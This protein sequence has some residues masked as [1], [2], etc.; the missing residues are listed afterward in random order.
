MS[1]ARD[2][3]VTVVSHPAILPSNQEVYRALLER[4]FDV[5]LVV[6]T[7]WPHPY[8]DDPLLPVALE[9]MEGR[10]HPVP[11]AL[12]GR[13]QR[14]VPLRSPRGILRHL[15]P[16]VL[17]IEEE[18]FAVATAVW[19]RAAWKLRIP[20]GVQIDE[21]MDRPMPGAA[22]RWRTTVL[23]R[24]SFVMA[25]SD[26]AIDQARA[27]G[28]SGEVAMIAHAVEAWEQPAHVVDERFRIGYIGRLVAEK[29]LA[30]L[31]DAAELMS[32]PPRLVLVGSGPMAGQLGRSPLVEL[33]APVPH[34]EIPR[35]MAE[36][37]VLALP[38][39]STATWTEQFGRVLV[40]ANVCAVPVVG[41]DS[42]EI[43]WVI[44]TT[45]GGVIVPEGD[46][47]ALAD[48]LSGLRDDPARARALGST[49]R[50]SVL[51][52][53]SVDVVTDKLAQMLRR[54]SGE[55]ISSS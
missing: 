40:E 39:R 13:P 3:R 28:A 52:T 8:Q 37:D 44:S 54:A 42:G 7:S 55:R 1:R 43:P 15:Q 19:A 49:G 11:V 9:G 25:R 5:Q 18:P 29:G 45:G 34:H 27:W 24:A 4:G 48:A 30:D 22:K 14:H 47:A 17:V 38:S 31:L 16:E 50:S 51:S 23:E 6:P 36:L 10:L 33:R 20:F 35:V 41:S 26:Q 21:N 12:S 46:P 2:L 32:P 53:F